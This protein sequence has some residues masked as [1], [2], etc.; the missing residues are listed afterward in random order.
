MIQLS[1]I[2]AMHLI[3]VAEQ[4]CEVRLGQA[5]L[6]ARTTVEFDAAGSSCRQIQGCLQLATWCNDALAKRDQMH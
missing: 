6:Q 1:G 4:C 2:S 3:Q 5:A